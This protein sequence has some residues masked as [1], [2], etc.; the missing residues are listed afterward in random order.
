VHYWVNYTILTYISKF[1]PEMDLF[2]RPDRPQV[3][4]NAYL[5]M[6]W[7][8]WMHLFRMYHVF[9]SSFCFVIA[10]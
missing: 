6:A 9:S 8:W 7:W 1:L 4:I 10:A 3:L 5:R 2:L